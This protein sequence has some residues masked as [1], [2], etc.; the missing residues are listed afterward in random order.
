M[1]S[2]LLLYFFF[3]ENLRESAL[4]ERKKWKIAK[5][6]QN[7]YLGGW[8]I[9]LLTRGGKYGVRLK[10]GTCRHSLLSDV[11][12]ERHRKA[13]LFLCSALSRVGRRTPRVA[14][15]H[16]ALFGRFD[17]INGHLS[18]GQKDPSSFLE[19]LNSNDIAIY[20]VQQTCMLLPD[21]WRGA[22]RR[23]NKDK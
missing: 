10:C 22:P 4:K 12:K 16:S 19:R 2:R 1:N 14:M 8:G 17:P 13:F 9:Q 11:G 6:T 5:R 20:P 23:S 7:T 21:V 18:P 3:P 15:S